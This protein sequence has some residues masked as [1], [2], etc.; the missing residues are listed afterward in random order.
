MVR[1][2]AARAKLALAFW[3]PLAFFGLT[4]S[5]RSAEVYD[6]VDRGFVHESRCT[7]GSASC[8]VSNREFEFGVRPLS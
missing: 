6:I 1:S 5:E 4:R 7:V 3:M 2:V 8:G